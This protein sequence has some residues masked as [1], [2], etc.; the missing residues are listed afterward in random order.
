MSLTTISILIAMLLYFLGG[1]LLT[2]QVSMELEE[3]QDLPTRSWLF[4]FFL[5]PV[6][7]AFDVWFTVLDALGKPKNPDN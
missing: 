2:H 1:V 7:A 3:D 5:W 4:I 6:E